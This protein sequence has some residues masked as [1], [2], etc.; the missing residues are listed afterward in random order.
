MTGRH[1]SLTQYSTSVQPSMV[2]HWNTVS[3]ANRKLSKFVMPLL[4]P[5]QPS[6]H[7]MPLREQWRPWPEREQGAG[8]S[9]A[10]VPV[11]RVRK[12]WLILR[13]WCHLYLCTVCIS[14]LV[15]IYLRPI[16]WS[17][18]VCVCVCV[19]LP[20]VTFVDDAIKLHYTSA[21]LK[22]YFL[23]IVICIVIHND[24]WEWRFHFH[25][26]CVVGLSWGL[27]VM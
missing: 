18:F 3:M 19:C 24:V 14:T 9:S 12:M 17:L 2:I 13:K 6:L 21:I 10:N 1:A 25:G 26:N 20:S 23:C 27:L 7:I 5:C 11:W 16:I 4:G 22:P 15:R 8:S